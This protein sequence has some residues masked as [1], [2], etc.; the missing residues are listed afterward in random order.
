MHAES[1]RK[2][3]RPGY[4]RR[5][6]GNESGVG[7][8]AGVV[9]VH[10]GFHWKR[11]YISDINMASWAGYRMSLYMELNITIEDVLLS[12]FPPRSYT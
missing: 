4:R 6:R 8:S 7:V 3:R 1:S 12:Y 2:R 10:G 9:V 5:R 11:V